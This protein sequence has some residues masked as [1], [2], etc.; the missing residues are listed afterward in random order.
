MLARGAA[1][2]DAPQGLGLSLEMTTGP[3]RTGDG[4]AGH[5]EGPHW[6]CCKTWVGFREWFPGSSIEEMESAGGGIAWGGQGPG[7]G[8]P[9]C[10]QGGWQQ[11]GA[12]EGPCEGPY[13]DRTEVGDGS[14]PRADTPEG[15]PRLQG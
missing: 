5:M 11:R 9:R 2:R 15:T 3:L 6:H 8:S 10:V 4:T 7:Q 14:K 12:A 1:H 13:R